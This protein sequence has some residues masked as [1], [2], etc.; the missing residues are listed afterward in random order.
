MI[1]LEPPLRAQGQQPACEKTWGDVVHKRLKCSLWGW[2][3]WNRLAGALSPAQKT[4][5]PFLRH[6][7]VLPGIGGR[8]SFT[9]V[10]PV[11]SLRAHIQKDPALG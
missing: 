4:G 5:P 9:S 8:T 10:C 2:G 3:H 11:Q 1:S 7:Q 6:A